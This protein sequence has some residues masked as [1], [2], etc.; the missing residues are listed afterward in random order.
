MSL[1]RSHKTI[2]NMGL[3]S[4]EN[5]VILGDNQYSLTDEK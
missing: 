5:T 4:K 2:Q 3:F 1:A